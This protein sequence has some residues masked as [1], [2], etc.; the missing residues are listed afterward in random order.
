MGWRIVAQP[1]GLYA[2]FSDVVDDFT[3]INMTRE[4]ALK[5][6]RNYS[7]MGEFESEAKV[8]RGEDD[9]FRFVEEIRS[10]RVIHGDERADYLIKMCSKD[11]ED[12][13]A[14][15]SG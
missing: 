11:W 13:D 5:E 1:N 7:G 10:V 6:C 15:L 12:D 8:K 14:K 3:N 2:R 4:E 9:T